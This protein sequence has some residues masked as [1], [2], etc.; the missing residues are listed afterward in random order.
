MPEWCDLVRGRSHRQRPRARPGSRSCSGLD[1]AGPLGLHL[2]DRSVEDRC[3]FKLEGL[4][5]LPELVE[6]FNK[7]DDYEASVASGLSRSSSASR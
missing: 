3:L 1:P 2:K 4:A 5:E 7:K 6:E